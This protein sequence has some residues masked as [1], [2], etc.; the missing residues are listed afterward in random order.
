MSNAPIDHQSYY[1]RLREINIGDVAR[2]LLPGKI[3]QESTARLQCDCPNHASNTKRS[4]HINLAAQTFYCFGC[5]IGGDVI[6]FVEF[7][8]A[9]TITKGHKGTMP[10]SHRKA[11]DWLA[12]KQGLPSMGELGLTP[13]ELKEFKRQRTEEE[14]V[15]GCLGALADYYHEQLITSSEILTQFQTKYGIDEKTIEDQRIGYADNHGAIEY[16]ASKGYTWA[17]KDT[18]LVACG[19][20]ASDFQDRPRPFF[21]Y[22]YTFPYYNNGQTIYMIGRRTDKTPEKDESK[23]KKLP[24]WDQ[25]KHPKVSRCIRNDV[26]YNEHVLGARPPYVILSEGITD[27]I[28]AMANGFPAISP[29]TVNVRK[30]DRPRLAEKLKRSGSTVIICYDNEISQAGYEGAIKTAQWLE[31]EQIPAKIAVLQPTEAQVTAREEIDET[32]KISPSMNGKEVTEA[33]KKIPLEDLKEFERLSSVAKQD[34]NSYFLNF[35]AADFQKLI[36]EAPTRLGLVIK[37]RHDRIKE[38]DFS[39]LNDTQFLLA[40]SQAQHSDAALHAETMELVK[41]NKWTTSLKTAIKGTLE[42]NRNSI[43]DSPTKQTVAQLCEKEG[44]QPPGGCPDHEVPAGCEFGPQGFCWM[45]YFATKV[46]REPFH[47][48]LI[49]I[50]K[51]TQDIISGNINFTVA[52][53][54]NG[55]W[56][57]ITIP[58]GDAFNPRNLVEYS[59]QGL[60]VPA[61]YAKS[62]SKF[63]FEYERL[64]DQRIHTET[65]SSQMGYVGKDNSLFLYGDT[66]VGSEQIQFVPRDSGDAQAARGLTK[67]GL[68]DTWIDLAAKIIPNYPRISVLFYSAMTAFTLRILGLKTFIVD[69]SAPT[70]SGKTIATRLVMSAIGDPSELVRSWN[71]T[72]VGLERTAAIQKDFPLCL[73]D[74]KSGNVQKYAQHAYHL[75]EEVG[76]LRGSKGGGLTTTQHWK[77]V[78]LSTGEASLA[79]Y[80]PE[81]GGRARVLPLTGYPLDKVGPTTRKLVGEIER[82]IADNYG[83]IGP[84][85]VQYLIDNQASW[86]QW[87]AEYHELNQ[88]RSA[89]S[90]IAGRFANIMTAITFTAHLLHNSGLLPWDFIDPFTF[91]SE[92]L[93]YAI[94]EADIGPRSLRDVYNWA[95]SSINRFWPRYCKLDDGAD[96]KNLPTE[97]YGRWDKGFWQFLGIIP[98]ILDRQ[99]ALMDYDP[100]A[101]LAAWKERGWL[102]TPKKGIRKSVRIG[103]GTLTMYVIK[104]S[105]FR[106]VLGHNPDDTDQ[107]VVSL[108]ALDKDYEEAQPVQDTEYD[109]TK[110]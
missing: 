60:S 27:C 22:R 84:E 90:G 12:A 36:D 55:H 58:R 21:Q 74:T 83:H 71:A 54:K 4:L 109:L 20:F 66:C 53:E 39:V 2:E 72:S 33:K 1:S 100:K 47:P 59:N 63:F 67:Q 81:G 103:T 38:K 44:L 34:I 62:A 41:K 88:K 77:T 94:E 92:D 106:E 101:V 51:R 29:I 97:I 26:L 16:L 42:N 15:Y 11:R 24:T 70:S 45:K 99:L 25:D 85:F 76:R 40:M 82:T 98:H 86:E 110:M 31:S 43:P 64:N 102:E 57:E 48:S 49:F 17:E 89:S 105:A 56:R 52:W 8:Q 95:G 61:D 69:L 75:T 5:G 23:Y 65:V 108:K 93:E 80:I 32:F 30:N 50:S 87:R 13:E 18:P 107:E 14:R 46:E 91:I 7:V 68:R 35:S 96:D 19:A 78:V 28:S 37:A 104:R 9:K 79:D 73:D 3:T 6:Q 10:E